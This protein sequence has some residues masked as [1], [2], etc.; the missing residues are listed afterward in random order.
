MKLLKAL[1]VTLFLMCAV[2][3]PMA[4]QIT[5][6]NSDGTFTDNGGNAIGTSTLSL[7]GSTLTDVTGLSMY[8]VNP[9]PPAGSSVSFTTGTL[10]TNSITTLGVGQTATFNPS[11]SNSFTINYGGGVIF[12]GSFTGTQSWINSG[13]AYTFT[14]QVNGTLYVPGYNPV[15]IMG[16][17]VQL[18]TLNDTWTGNTIQDGINNING[19]TFTLPAGGLSPVPEPGTLSLLG[20][21]LVGLGFFVRRFGIGRTSVK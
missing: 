18:T 21:G 16:A 20:S 13:I 14:A 8:G 10:A 4:A 11:P 7:S 5:F 2:C 3:A 12:T 17:T 6:S 9:T 19:T 1:S 15:T